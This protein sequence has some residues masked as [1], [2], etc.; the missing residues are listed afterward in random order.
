MQVV[1][2]RILDYVSAGLMSSSALDSRIEAV[3]RLQEK[4]DSHG[5]E[6]IWPNSH[7]C[8][9]YAREPLKLVE[10]FERLYLDSYL[11][12]LMSLKSRLDEGG[13]EEEDD[14]PQILVDAFT[15]LDSDLG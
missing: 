13:E 7:S 10:R 8:V 1:S 5:G 2:R 11:A 3:R 6:G 12:H 15:A 14:I 4:D 9:S